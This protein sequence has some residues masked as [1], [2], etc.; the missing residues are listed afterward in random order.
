MSS[1]KIRRQI[2]MVIPML[3]VIL[4]IGWFML[5]NNATTVDGKIY[6]AGNYQIKIA[7]NPKKPRAGINKLT[8]LILDNKGQAIN[9]AKIKATAIMPAMGS[10]PE[11]RAPVEIKPLSNG[12]YHGEFDL[13][14]AGAWPLTINIESP[15][16]GQ[17]KLQFDLNTSQIG[18]TL[19]NASP[20]SQMSSVEQTSGDTGNAKSKPELDA[21]GFAIAGK[22]RVRISITPNPPKVGNNKIKVEVKSKQ[23]K[24]IEKA[25][26]RALAQYHPDEKTPASNLM[27]KIIEDGKGIYHGEFK[28]TQAGNWPLAIDVE[29]SE[30][31]HGDLVYDMT[32]GQKTLTLKTATPGTISHYTCSMHPSVKSKAPGT[33]PIC[34]MNLVPV[35]KKEVTSGIIRVSAKRRQLI[36]VTTG[37]VERKEFIKTIRAAGR[38]TYNESKVTDI[39]LKFNGWVGKLYANY[40]G[41]AVKKGQP[42]FTI[43]S[44]DLV[45]AQE[46]YLEAIRRRSNKNNPLVKA[47]IRRLL[48]WNISQDQI[49]TLTRTRKALEYMPILSPVTGT[50]VKKNIVAGSSFKASKTLLRITDLSTV[51]VEG[52]IY[53]YEIA[54]VKV[55]MDVK[56]LLPDITGPPIPGKITYIYPFLE[57]GS[58][59]N[60][61]RVE[62]ENKDGKLRPNMYAHVHILVDQGRK[63]VVPESAVLYSGLNRVV[64]IDLGGGRLQPR[65]IEIGSRNDNYIEV[66]KGLNVGDVV[67]TSGNFLIGAESKLKSGVDQW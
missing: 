51:W 4:A 11:M 10:M 52:Q 39:S 30:F 9:N 14:M 62:L 47:S 45:S 7:I 5:G 60:R 32:T 31:G 53:E 28:L 17:A 33:C 56:V 65:K 6:K 41:T 44:P 42:L 66:K 43:Y 13:S 34:S 1:K 8:L 46:E 26:I 61:I 27:I 67:V 64:F 16:Y 15:T 59:T 40:V 38:V 57:S 21:E 48:R 55:G 58:R 49:N 23:G 35:S 3:S 20:S 54:N 18:L 29:T 19:E 2:I 24:P 22:F 63:L 12:R 50:V 36:G 25:K 37:K